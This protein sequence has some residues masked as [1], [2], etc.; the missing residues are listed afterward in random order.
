VCDAET[1]EDI[2]S[3]SGE[4]VVALAVFFGKARLID[5]IILKMEVGEKN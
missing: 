2:V 1:L 4:A 3:V 5:N